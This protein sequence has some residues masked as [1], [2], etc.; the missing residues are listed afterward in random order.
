M[1]LLLVEPPG[2]HARSS[3]ALSL[4]WC[5]CIVTSCLA[6]PYQGHEE[7]KFEDSNAQEFLFLEAP[8]PKW[9]GPGHTSWQTH[10]LPRGSKC[11]HTKKTPTGE[12]VT[13]TAG[14]CSEREMAIV[15]G[16]Q[17]GGPREDGDVSGEDLPAS[18]WSSPLARGF[19]LYSIAHKV[20]N[21]AGARW[22]C[23]VVPV[24]I[25]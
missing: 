3:I 9:V 5:I 23:S 13:L 10:Q 25:S 2:R 7:K 16:A 17:D 11:G 18:T 15:G 4:S 8:C 6:R 19:F 24:P 21:R 20:C 22:V 1:S 12:R 14:R